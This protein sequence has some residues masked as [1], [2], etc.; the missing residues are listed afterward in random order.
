MF[1]LIALLLIIATYATKIT[2]KLGIPVLLLFLGIGMLIGSDALN[3]IYFDDA[4][5][6][7]KI[8][9]KENLFIMWGGIKGAVPIVLATYPA[10]YGLDDNHFIFN[11]VFFAVFL[12][13][14]LQGTTIGWVAER[15]KLSIPSLPKSRHSIELITTQ[16]SDIDVFEIQIPEISSIDGTRLRELNLPPDSLITSIMRENYIIIPKEDTILKKHD[17]LFVI[18]PYKETDLIRS[19]LSK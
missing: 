14:L 13:C 12:S 7:Q 19:E 10:V 3:F 15:L 9:N 5:L 2:S 18:A 16:K 4:V 11:I 1:L 6:T 8:A 17:I